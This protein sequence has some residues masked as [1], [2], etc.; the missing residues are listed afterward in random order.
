MDRIKSRNLC[1]NHPDPNDFIPLAVDTTDRLYEDFIRL[2]FL[3]A[4][5]EASGFDNGESIGYVDFMWISISLDLSSRSSIPLPRFIR[6]CRPT[7]ILVPSLVLVF[8]FFYSDENKHTHSFL[9]P[10]VFAFF[11]S[12][13]NKLSETFRTLPSLCVVFSFSS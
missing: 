5:R 9:F 2:L 4:H 8:A 12:D 11:C 10:L 7:T 3:Y 13:E 1:L 6:S